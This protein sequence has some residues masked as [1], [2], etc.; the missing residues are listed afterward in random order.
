M[1]DFMLNEVIPRHVSMIHTHTHYFHKKTMRFLKTKIIDHFLLFFLFF[2]LELLLLG[3]VG[4]FEFERDLFDFRFLLD[5][6]LS[7]SSVDDSS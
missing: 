3:V 4:D 1:Q 6:E 2:L 7:L 5:L